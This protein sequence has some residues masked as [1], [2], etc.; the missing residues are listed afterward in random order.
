MDDPSDTATKHRRDDPGARARYDH[1][2]YSWALEQAALL[3]AGRLSEV[4]AAHIAEE[5]DDAGNE[6]YDKLERAL[7]LILL[8]LLKWDYQPE[9]RSRSWRLS[10]SVHPKHVSKVLRKNPDLKP[11]VDETITEAYE[12][13]RV[14]AAG[15]TLLEDDVFPLECPYS[16][17]EIVERPITWPPDA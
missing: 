15:Q 13:A 4:D 16:W 7:R 11:L 9:R 17:N 14:E 8:H 10:I 2:L 3:G 12:V 5:I 6:Q 1:D